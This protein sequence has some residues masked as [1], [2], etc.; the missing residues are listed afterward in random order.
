VR[1]LLAG[2][3][4]CLLAALLLVLVDGVGR[5]DPHLAASWLQDAEWACTA[6]WSDRWP[7]FRTRACGTKGQFTLDRRRWKVRTVSLRWL[8]LGSSG[9]F[10]RQGAILTS[11]STGFQGAV[12]PRE[13]SAL[14]GS[15]VP[16]TS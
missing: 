14:L 3:T 11:V 5:E 2:L 9:K 7:R 1:G 16:R 13:R 8:R 10:P 12:A 15:F 4:V 6:I